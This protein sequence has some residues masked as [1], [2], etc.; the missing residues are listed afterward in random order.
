ISAQTDTSNISLNNTKVVFCD[1]VPVVDHVVI[2]WATSKES[3]NMYFTIERSKDGKK[4]TKVIDVPG[5]GNSKTYREY[6]ETDYQPFKETSYY[7]IKQTDYN[8]NFKYFPV[9]GVMFNAEKNG[10]F[11]PDQA[12]AKS[13]VDPNGGLNQEVLVVLQDAEGVEFSAKVTITQEDSQL[14]ATDTSQRVPPGIYIIISSSDENIY[15][16]KIIVK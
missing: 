4:Y 8:G 3:T 15:S 13:S 6:V 5:S 9:T 2:S 10:K 16:Q 1:V 11:Y 7:R 14:F 12:H